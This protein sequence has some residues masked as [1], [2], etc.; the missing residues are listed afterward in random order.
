MWIKLYN[1]EMKKWQ[2][3]IFGSENVKKL[4]KENKYI[5]ERSVHNL[6]NLIRHNLKWDIQLAQT[7]VLDYF[8]CLYWRM[9]Q[10]VRT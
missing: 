9:D 3:S 5:K 2:K 4:V 7:Y 8:T 1:K 6:L 10:Q